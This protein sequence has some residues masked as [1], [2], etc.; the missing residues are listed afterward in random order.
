MENSALQAQ[1]TELQDQV[2]SPQDSQLVQ[3][4]AALAALQA[5]HQALFADL[6]KTRNEKASLQAKVLRA[7]TA[8]ADD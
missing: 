3:A 2:A 8:L 6:E 5:S 1:V 7:Q 4:A